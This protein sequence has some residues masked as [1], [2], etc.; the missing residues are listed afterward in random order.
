MVNIMVVD[1]E[2]AVITTIKQGFD[3]LTD[4]YKVLGV[5]SG[6]ECIEILK[7]GGK[8]DIILLDIMMPDLDGWQVYD[9]LKKNEE[10]SEIPV[11]FITAKDD[12]ETI[13]KGIE[14]NT[15]CV[16]KPFKIKELKDKIERV[17]SEDFDF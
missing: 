4:R 3:M 9:I 17:L 13:K 16:R 5:N 15:Y 6:K 7:E 14:T 8:P 1:D 11:I 2:P 12:E 10:W